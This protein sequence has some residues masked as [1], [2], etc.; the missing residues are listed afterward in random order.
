MVKAGDQGDGPV[1]NADQFGIM[2]RP[3][4]EHQGAVPEGVEEALKGGPVGEVRDR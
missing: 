1:G 3:S 2:E 4:K